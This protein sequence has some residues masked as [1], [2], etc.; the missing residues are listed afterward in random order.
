MTPR[1]LPRNPNV[2][3][4]EA[5]HFLQDFRQGDTSALARFSL[6]NLL[7]DTPNPRLADAQHMVARE[8]G[9]ASWPKLKQ[10]LDAMARDSDILEE[11]VGL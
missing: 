11:L 8:Y 1:T 3:N 7:P 4:G 2:I 5:R 9:Y 6:L 10:H